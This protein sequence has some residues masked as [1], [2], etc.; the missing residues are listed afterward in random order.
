M[1][2]LVFSS[3]TSITL[4]HRAV[5]E[6]VE[7]VEWVRSDKHYSTVRVDTLP[8]VSEFD[9]LEH[10]NEAVSAGFL[11]RCMVVYKPAGS[12]RCDRLVR[13]S[14]ASMT[15]GLARGGSVES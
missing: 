13:S 1:R 5:V 15:G 4:D 14:A 7:S 2:F 10:C 11:E 3:L 12:L 8:Q 9:G 6:V